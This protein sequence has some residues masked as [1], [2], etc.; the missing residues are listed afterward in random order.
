MLL[1]K[2]QWGSN[3]DTFYYD[4]RVDSLL[5]MAKP[6]SNMSLRYAFYRQAERIVI[7]QAPWVFLYHPVNYVIRQSWVNDYV[8][9]PMRPTRF[10]KIWLSPHGKQKKVALSENS[11][12]RSE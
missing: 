12:S 7:D 10:E 11:G 4:P 1:S 3:N 5:A 8:L 6:L 9:N 2:K